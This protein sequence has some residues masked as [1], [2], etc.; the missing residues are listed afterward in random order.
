MFKGS[1]FNWHVESLV[2]RVVTLRC[3]I[4]CAVTIC[5]SV[6]VHQSYTGNYCFH[7][8]VAAFLFGVLFNYS[9]SGNR[10]ILMVGRILPNYTVLRTRTVYSWSRTVPTSEF[11][12][13][14]IAG[15]D[16][17]KGMALRLRRMVWYSRRARTS[18]LVLKPFEWI[19]TEMWLY[20]FYL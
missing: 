19:G 5:R 10:P 11:R 16:C 3:A 14:S 8:Q 4:F 13:A 15:G 9:N 18:P 2:L 20:N 6:E 17:R 1:M 12:T 7:L